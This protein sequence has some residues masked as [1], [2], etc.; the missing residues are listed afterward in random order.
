MNSRLRDEEFLTLFNETLKLMVDCG[1]KNPRQAAVR[2]A[3]ANGAPRYAVSFERAY[4]VVCGML[5]GQTFHKGENHLAMWRELTER[6]RL[7]VAESGISVARALEHVLTHC[8]A[9]RYFMDERYA[10]RNSYRLAQR[11]RRRIERRFS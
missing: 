11:R 3:L 5:R 10:Y 1:V 9:S 4:D 8:R 7:L 2:F 6:V